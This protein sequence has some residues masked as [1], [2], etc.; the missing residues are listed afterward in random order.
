MFTPDT[1]QIGSGRVPIEADHAAPDHYDHHDHLGMLP[2]EIGPVP[3]VAE[4]T[5]GHWSHRHLFTNH[6]ATL[7]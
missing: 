5:A 3:A 4:I 6:Q 7:R 2:F 1:V